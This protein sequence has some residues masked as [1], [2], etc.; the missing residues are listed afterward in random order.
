MHR[1]AMIAASRAIMRR[2]CVVAGAAVMLW[3]SSFARTTQVAAQDDPAVPSLEVGVPV[4][5]VLLGGQEDT[6]RVEL[7]SDQ[8]AR[9]LV[10]GVGIHVAVALLGPDATVLSDFA[11]EDRH[12]GREQIELVAPA[13]GRYRLVVRPALRN[14]QSGRYV[15]RVV[16]TRNA[17]DDDRQMEE[18]RQLGTA[19]QRLRDQGKFDEAF[20]VV[21]HA[22]A[23]VERLRERDDP[24]AARLIVDLAEISIDQWNHAKAVSQYERAAAIFEK[25]IGSDQPETAAAWQGLALEYWQTGQRSKAEKLV[26]RALETTENALGPDHPLVARCL[27]TL[28]LLRTAA[29]DVE[30]AEQIE[31]RALA[32]VEKCLGIDNLL[33]SDLLNNLALNYLDKREYDRADDLLTRSLRIQERLRG[34]EGYGM[35]VTLQ[36]LGIVARQRKDYAKA[37]EYYRHVLSIRRTVLGADH[38]EIAPILNNLALVYRDTGDFAKALDTHFE[39]LRIWEKSSGP[40][41]RLVLTS[42]GNIARTYAAAG[43]IPNAIEYQRRADAVIED[44]LALNLAIGSERQRLAFVESVVSPRTDRTIS[45]SFDQAHDDPNAGSLAALVILQRKGRVLD[46]MTDSFSAMRERIGEAADRGILDQLGATMKRLA[47]VALNRPPDMSAAEQRQT[48]NHLEEEKEKLEAKISEHSAEFR[49]RSLP[50]TLDAVQAVLPAD[51]A[52]IEFAVFHPFNPEAENNNDAYAAAHY[53]AYVITGHA[54]RGKDLGP[55]ASVDSAVE[56]FRQALH[57][58]GR[59]DVAARGR[60]IDQLVMQPI[61]TLIGDSRRLLISPDGDLSLIPFEA[62]VDEHDRYEIEH[63][64]ITYL[65][66]G[67]DLLRMQVPRLAKSDPII[68]ADPAFG[69]PTDSAAPSSPQTSARVR[70]IRRSVT[71][72][73]DLST[74]YFAPLA[75]TAEE[76]RAIKT[77]F[78]EARVLSRELATKA[79]LASLDAPRILHIATHGFFLEDPATHAIPAAAQTRAISVS[80]HVENPLLRSGLA[81]SGANVTKGASDEGILTALEASNL[82]LWGTKLV[83]LSACDTGVGQVRIGE[84]VYGLRRAFFLAGAETLV[85]SLWPVS[86]LVTRQMMTAYY[87]GLKAGRGRGDALRQAQLSLMARPGRRHPF[88]WASFI[89][90]GEWANLNGQR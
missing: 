24:S 89:Q 32:I 20:D 46:A 45:L 70:P 21:G 64:A 9:V 58:P 18:A 40:Y 72:A 34:P 28:G 66:S 37:E 6:Y 88:Y 4:E 74:V 86:D 1:L 68:V 53:A 39:A 13:S 14:L 79:M 50:V 87:G 25:A 3:L 47:G 2:A 84:G 56:A 42:L 31:R 22:L 30:K 49:S 69:E 80:A 73:S 44:Q 71:T 33:Y 54:A 83:T 78:P 12:F 57:D 52:L 85:M 11:K 61:R 81:L 23:I 62:L 8:Y 90:A 10:D 75:G 76:A 16:E 55:A 51:A 17:T 60:A 35:S 26:E 82:N 38:P 65:T 36:N 63:Y 43:E 7:Q 59:A 5:R 15:I 29:G 41:D 67:R 27:L 48:I 77:R 19:A